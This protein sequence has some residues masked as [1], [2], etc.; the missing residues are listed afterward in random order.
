MADIGR[1]R[2]FRSK[3]H[4][5]RESE[6]VDIIEMSQSGARLALI[7]LEYLEA[8]AEIYVVPLALAMGEEARHLLAER[9]ESIVAE[10]SGLDGEAVLYDAMRLPGLSHE[11]LRL[12]SSKRRIRGRRTTL[13]SL[14]VRGS[15]V[16]SRL[17]GELA[18]RGGEA[19]Q[20]NTSVFFGEQLM[21]KLFRKL[22][23]GPNPEVEL[24]RFL[25]EDRGFEN[26]PRARGLVMAE[27]G[28]EEAV[29]AF[30]QDF[31]PGHH[32]LFGHTFDGAVLTLETLL[33]SGHEPAAPPRRRHPLDVTE[34]DLDG[35]SELMGAHLAE[36]RLLGQ[37]TGEMHLALASDPTHPVFAPEP[38]STL[39]QRSV[40][41]SI[42]STVRTSLGMLRRR[43]SK[44]ETHDTDLIDRAVASE[45]EILDMI[46]QITADRIECDR[47]RIH[48]DFH[49]GQVLFTGN[50]FFIIDFEGEP[51]RP[52]SQR[53]LKRLALR[54]VA[55]MI[56]SYHYAMVMAL[57]QVA[58]AGIDDETRNA[59]EQWAEAIHSWLSAAFLTGYRGAVDGSR[60]VP[61]DSAHFRLLLDAL[62]VEKAA[63]EL[64]Y[65]V[66]N[67]PDWVDIPL[68]GILNVVS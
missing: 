58:E 41:Q 66:N 45:G 52:L 51:Q 22:E 39:Q 61:K 13:H 23:A 2:W 8:E 38:M 62:I 10:V 33:A 56:R 17:A 25:T 27:T 3:A 63:Y 20:S 40:Y 49:L 24:G 57:R 30:F 64:E 11:L 19:E 7:R 55:G 9:P 6:L 12:A 21:M 37:R 44:L 26:T 29:L 16:L 36:A 15:T 47:I 43:R 48:G 59:L 60:I 18:V 28:G 42:R 53:R 1:R 68:Q 67:R 14:P 65:E 34:A 32:D 31:V 46:K 54:D 4:T 50:D 5:V 35:A